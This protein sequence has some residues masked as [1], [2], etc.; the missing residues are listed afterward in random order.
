MRLEGQAEGQG[1]VRPGVRLLPYT[2]G[3]ETVCLGRRELPANWSAT[4]E[5]AVAAAAV[6]QKA[7]VVVVVVVGERVS[8]VVG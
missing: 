7:S 6:E 8:V 4:A 2:E 5:L 3:V 1:R